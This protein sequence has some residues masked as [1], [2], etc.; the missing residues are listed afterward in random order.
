MPSYVA[1]GK[2]VREKQRGDMK[3]A[4]A[5]GWAVEHH[6][7]RSWALEE[8]IPALILLANYEKVLL[9]TSW[10]APNPA[11]MAQGARN[12]TEC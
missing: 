4:M 12:R 2:I 11:S 5:R 7:D 1:K 10:I 9:A 6:V 8:D 3:E